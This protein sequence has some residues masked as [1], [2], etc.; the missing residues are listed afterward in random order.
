MNDIDLKT[1]RKYS[2]DIINLIDYFT[3]SPLRTVE[4][5]KN[6]HTFI[7][8]ETAIVGGHIINDKIVSFIWCYQRK[9]G[10]T[11]RLH[12]SYFIVDDEFRGQ[13]LSK[14]LLTFAKRKAEQLN[15][16]LIDLNV[17]PEN[18]TAIK[19]YKN[20]GFIT[21]KLQLVMEVNKDD[22]DV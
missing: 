2:K 5:M 11:K 17:E 14:D 18:E 16:K 19:V 10:G 22:K 21:E 6:L 20:S 1:Y 8:N 15:I 3:K 13:G 7:E 12:I 9:F 4:V